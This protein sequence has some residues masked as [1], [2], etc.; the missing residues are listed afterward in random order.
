MP[1]DGVPCGVLICADL[2]YPEQVRE[3]AASADIL[4]VPA[5]TT[6]RPESQPAYARL[7][8]QTLA[9]TRAQENVLA[10]VVSDQ[11][12]ILLCAL[13][14]RRRCVDHRS[15]RRAGSGRHTTHT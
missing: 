6:I 10:V 12:A 8:W 11:A 1:L 2:W 5:Q 13:S 15:Q 3:L 9:M 14:L 4:C 7:L